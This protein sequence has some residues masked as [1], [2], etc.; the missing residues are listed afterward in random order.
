M[1]YL[2]SRALEAWFDGCLGSE[3]GL[4]KARQVELILARHGIEPRKVVFVGDAPRDH[5]LVR[6][7]GVRFVGIHRLF[8]AREFR[9]RGLLSVDGLAGLTRSW[10]RLE[11]LRRRAEPP[12]GGQVSWFARSKLADRRD[13]AETRHEDAEIAAAATARIAGSERRSAARIVQ[14]GLAIAASRLQ[15]MVE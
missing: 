2:R 12:V 7:T 14:G 11:R 5:E 9:R 10:E 15:D 4:G 3:P 1:S 8:D 13:K 6:G